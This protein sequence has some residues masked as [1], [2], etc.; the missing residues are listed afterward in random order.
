[1]TEHYK[2]S[3]GN[4]ECRPGGTEDHARQG[5]QFRDGASVRDRA[6]NFSDQKCQRPQS[7]TESFHSRGGIE[8]PQEQDEG[9]P[10][11]IE[12][13]AHRARELLNIAHTN[14][15]LPVSAPEGPVDFDVCAQDTSKRFLDNIAR[16]IEHQSLPGAVDSEELP[17]AANIPVVNTTGS[18]H[19]PRGEFPEDNSPQSQ[20]D[21]GDTVA[22][23]RVKDQTNQNYL[24]RF[25]LDSD[26]LSGTD[27]PGYYE[28]HEG[29]A[30][31]PE[32]DLS[33][34]GKLLEKKDISNSWLP[35]STS[36]AGESLDRIRPRLMENDNPHVLASRLPEPTPKK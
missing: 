31:W 19:W 11:D 34:E 30:N 2:L 21:V 18:L 15:A 24:N 32:L 8:E 23:H 36:Q 22:L 14:R 33:L 27:P 10:E 5:Q 6:A 25:L 4:Q 3:S 26:D 12:Q 17:K 9:L 7:R 1:M 35:T 28:A 13:L 20:I 29:L 16:M